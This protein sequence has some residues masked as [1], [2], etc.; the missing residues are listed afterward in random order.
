MAAHLAVAL[1]HFDFY[2]YTLPDLQRG[3][4]RMCNSVMAAEKSA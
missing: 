1:S 3:L 4:V 2:F